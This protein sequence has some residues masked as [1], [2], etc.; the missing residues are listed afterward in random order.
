MVRTKVWIICFLA[1]L[2]LCA[3]L[4]VLF[5]LHPAKGSVANVYVDGVCVASVDLSAVEEPYEW[6]VTDGQGGYN[7]LRVEPGRICVLD[8]DCPDHV[9]M[10]RG[11]LSDGNEPIVCL[12][13]RLV[14]RLEERAADRETVPDAIAG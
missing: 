11:W 2:A 14:I 1:V 12:P 5:F 10:R 7:L 3:L 8:A 6:K 13:H 9:C 4:C